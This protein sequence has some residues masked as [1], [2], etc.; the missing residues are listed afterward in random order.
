MNYKFN[1]IYIEITNVCQFNC[2]FCPKTKREAKYM[3]PK[4]FENIVKQ[5]KGLTKTIYLHVLG[6]PLLHP[7]LDQLLTIAN[8]YGLTVNLTTNG[9]AIKQAED[10]LLKH[11]HLRKINF[12]LHAIED[13]NH[14][15][16]SLKD[17]LHNICSFTQKMLAKDTTTIIY[18]LWNTNKDYHQVLDY[19]Q[20]KYPEVNLVKEKSPQNG[21]RLAYRLFLNQDHEFVWPINS[22]AKE[23]NGYCL[24][25][26]KQL[27][28][29]VDGTVV[30][31]CLDSE[32]IINLGNI[33]QQSLLTIL[34][35]PKAQNIRQG[36][37]NNQAIEKLCQ[38]CSFKDRFNL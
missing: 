11:N 12:S 8:N 6:E 32:G 9:Y 14:L 38:T 5:V 26:I 18:R 35:S 34:N 7:E 10:I 22:C 19:L 2:S 29:L 25:L 15:T 4:E 33:H 23:Q 16:L 30:P 24:G 36:F 27:A 21:H 37:M 20:N 28:I 3:D 17:Y 13:Q 31:C 1:Q